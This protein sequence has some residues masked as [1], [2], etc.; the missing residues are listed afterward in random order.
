MVAILPGL[1]H[2][3]SG[4]RSRP[5]GSGLLLWQYGDMPNFRRVHLPGGTF[6]F[7]VVTDGRAPYLCDDSAPQ[8]L[9]DV[10]REVR[11][12]W[13][14]EVD[15][16]VVVPDHLHAIWTLPTED[17]DYSKRWAWV[18]KEFTKRWLQ[19][20]HSERVRSSGRAHDGRRGVW[21]P[22]FW[23]HAIRDERDLERHVEYIHYNPVKHGAARCPHEWRWSSFARWVRAGIHAADWACSCDPMAQVK[24]EFADLSRTVGE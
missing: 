4:R 18:K 2:P 15:A 22:K 3:G 7:T 6:F 1:L 8:L 20:G 5:Y 11:T 9:R 10:L 21:Q 14:F 12:R 24:V 17:S 16:I 13:P 23:E 19:S